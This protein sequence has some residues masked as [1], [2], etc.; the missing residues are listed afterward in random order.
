MRKN[1]KKHKQNNT[2]NNGKAKER[3]YSNTCYLQGR[4]LK[5][6]YYVNSGEKSMS[7]IRHKKQLT[8]QST[9]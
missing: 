4:K 6:G 1:N 5:T 7:K 8:Y 2:Q 3:V 9:T